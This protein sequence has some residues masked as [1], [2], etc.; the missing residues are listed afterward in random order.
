LPEK[1]SGMLQNFDQCADSR[2]ARTYSN[3]ADAGRNNPDKSKVAVSAGYKQ[4]V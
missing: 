3:S 2:E 4:D 1:F